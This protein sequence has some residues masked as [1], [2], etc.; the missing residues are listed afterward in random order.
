MAYIASSDE[1]IVITVTYLYVRRLMHIS[2]QIMEDILGYRFGVN[3]FFP[4]R[5]NVKYCY[6]PYFSYS[7]FGG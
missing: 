1:T 4:S 7:R 6:L 2:L 5:S 3:I